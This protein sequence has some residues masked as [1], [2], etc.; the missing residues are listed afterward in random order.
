MPCDP[1]GEEPDGGDEEPCGGG[2]DGLLEVLGEAA[3]AA[4]S[5]QRSFDDPA[6]GQDLKP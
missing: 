2:R 4:E 5:S 1:P 6:A 3:V